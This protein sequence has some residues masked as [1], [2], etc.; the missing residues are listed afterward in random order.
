MV[1][2]PRSSAYTLCLLWTPDSSKL[3][4]PLPWFGW[5]FLVQPRALIPSSVVGRE[6]SAGGA[7]CLPLFQAGRG[8]A[9]I[10]RRNRVFAEATLLRRLLSGLSP[11]LLSP[12]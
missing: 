5:V 7:G 2:K 3:G 10:T 6:G 12:Q 9:E 1:G 8:R 4:S 11:G